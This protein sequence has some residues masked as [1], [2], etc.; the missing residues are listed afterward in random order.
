MNF[1]V[2]AEK[3]RQLCRSYLSKLRLAFRRPYEQIKDTLNALVVSSIKKDR[4]EQTYVTAVTFSS[5]ILSLHSLAD[6]H[7]LKTIWRFYFHELWPNMTN[8]QAER[9]CAM[10]QGSKRTNLLQLRPTIKSNTIPLYMRSLFCREIPNKAQFEMTKL[11][12]GRA[13]GMLNPWWMIH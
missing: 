11:E 3:V 1:R 7:M 13:T 5:H 10:A 9:T 4:R 6:I 8:L 12:W 2:V